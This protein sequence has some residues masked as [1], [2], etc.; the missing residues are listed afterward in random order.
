MQVF[1]SH[2]QADEKLAR[3]LSGQLAEAGV[4]VWLAEQEV[5]PGDNLAL[6]VGKALQRSD[7]L[8]VLLSPES[9][10]S[11]YV[12]S[13]I[14]YALASARFQ[15]RVVPVMVKPTRNIPWFLKTLEIISVRATDSQAVEQLAQ[16]IVAALGGKVA[17][18]ELVAEPAGV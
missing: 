10:A 13:E 15:D 16:R 17:R 1:I 5:L 6:E 18:N 3:E 8:V 2:A 7:A 4:K 14:T 11:K 9:V 12:R